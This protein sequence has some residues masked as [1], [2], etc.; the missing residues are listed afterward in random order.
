MTLDDLKQILVRIEGIGPS[1]TFH[2]SSTSWVAILHGVDDGFDFS[3]T[4]TTIQGFK[5]FLKREHYPEGGGFHVSI[6][7]MDAQGGVVFHGQ[8]GERRNPSEYKLLLQWMIKELRPLIDAE[9][10]AQNLKNEAAKR[11][12]FK[13]TDSPK[14]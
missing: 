3:I 10:A 12:F 9:I 4:G 6:H 8:F 1:W 2:Q 7:V 11:E 13:L 5:I 14:R